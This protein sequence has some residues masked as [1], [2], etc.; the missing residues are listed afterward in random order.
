MAVGHDTK[1]ALST[2]E[3]RRGDPTRGGG[4]QGTGRQVHTHALV[5]EGGGGRRREGGR[6]GGGSGGQGKPGDSAYHRRRE[7]RTFFFCDTHT[8]HT[9]EAWDTRVIHD[10]R[11]ERK[12]IL[13]IPGDVLERGGGV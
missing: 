3:G 13:A 5:L 2:A 8:I 11:E 9:S 7:I 1:G 6:G 12:E 10:I 4:R